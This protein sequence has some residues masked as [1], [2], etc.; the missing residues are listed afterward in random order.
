VFPGLQGGPHFNTIAAIG[1]ALDEAATAG[2]RAYSRQIVA[3]AKRL[4][5]ALS[6]R[7]FHV[8]SGGTDNHLLL[9]DTRK[10][11][12]LPGKRVAQAL[13]DVSIILNFN[14]VP[15]ASDKQKPLAPDGIRMGTPSLTTRGMKEEHM[16][17]VAE[18]IERCVKNV[19]TGK[20]GKD[21]SPYLSDAAVTELKAEVEAFASK[22]PTFTYHQ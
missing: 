2:F 17:K 14:T 1:V 22:F 10:S 12:D 20:L 16:D 21:E 15:N 11:R 19:K 7:R 13:E 6:D 4:A 8:V 18:F 9:V 3:N 5:R